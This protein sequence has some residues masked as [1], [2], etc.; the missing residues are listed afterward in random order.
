MDGEGGEV[1]G[2]V[3]LGTVRQRGLL[4]WETKIGEGGEERFVAWGKKRAV[5]VKEGRVVEWRADEEGRFEGV[6]EWGEDLVEREREGREV[7]PPRGV[8]KRKRAVD[9]NVGRRVT[10]SMT[11]KEKEGRR[12]VTRSMT[13]AKRAKK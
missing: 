11:K 13:A 12:R 4:A 5:G 6:E 9:E 10:R 2:N 7:E 8:R 3:G 1:P